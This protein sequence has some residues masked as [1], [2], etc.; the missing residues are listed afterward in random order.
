MTDTSSPPGARTSFRTTVEGRTIMVTI[1]SKSQTI[2]ICKPGNVPGEYEARYRLTG[3]A[4]LTEGDVAA[5]PTLINLFD[6]LTSFGEAISREDDSRRQLLPGLIDPVDPSD[7]WWPTTTSII[8]REIDTLI[9][10][11]MRDPFLHRVEHSVHMQLYAALAAHPELA[12]HHRIGSTSRMTQLVHKEWP[13]TE[14]DEAS[15]SHRRG[16]YDLVVLAPRQLET[17]TLHHI[18][19]GRLAAGIVI[20][21][22]MNYGIEHLQQ[23]YD[24]LM[25]NK[26]RAGYLVHLSRDKS[27]DAVA[28]ALLLRADLSPS[29]KIAYAHCGESHVDRVY[30]LLG[31]SQLRA[32]TE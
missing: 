15:G 10:G 4:P 19:T 14:I 29:I 12:Q 23:D 20:E 8:E 5:H 2:A 18:R 24:K 17:A 27:R 32:W 26:I 31:D 1:G 3:E 7:P 9:D 16:A 25:A 13:E 21:M 30:K 22:G 11:F 28:E 6:W